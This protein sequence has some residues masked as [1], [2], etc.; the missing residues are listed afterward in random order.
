VFWDVV[1]FEHRAVG[2]EGYFADAGHVGHEGGS[3]C[4]SMINLCVLKA[5]GGPLPPRYTET[6]S[7]GD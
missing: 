1:E 3:N 4:F 5:A 6:I 2:E 7:R